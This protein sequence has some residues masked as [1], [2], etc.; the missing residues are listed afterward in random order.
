[1]LEKDIEN[2]I[3]TY[4]DEFFPDE[5]FKLIGQQ[6]VIENKRV[7][8]LFEDKH[9]RQIIVEI[10]RGILTREASGQI[11]EYYGL[12]KTANPNNHYELVLC[13][14]K[15]PAERKSFLEL[16][17][18]DCKEL[19]Y[20]K[21]TEIAKKYDYTFL[22]EKPSYKNQLKRE[23]AVLTEHGHSVS[24]HGDDDKNEASVW[25]FQA[26]ED[27]YD[28]L[29]AL[30]DPKIGNT[31]HWTVSRHKDRIRKGHLGLI[32]ISGSEA[33]IYAVVRVE[34]DPFLG[35]DTAE[36]QRYWIDVDDADDDNLR[37]RLTVIKRLINDPILKE[38]L[39]K[40]PGLQNM[41]VIKSPQGTN[42]RVRDSEWHIIGA[43]I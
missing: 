20:A 3:V 27:I 38:N 14:N 15:I 11:I 9:G 12:L 34:T 41:T 24:F 33:G 40:V 19:G 5:G 4:P 16:T 6:H 18:I 26:K 32:W 21:V 7:D 31:I 2:L 30:N 42:F 17:G 28:I 22:D 35:K 29:N 25:I 10:K 23:E 1:M 37:V 13:A 39:L 36:E 43:M 8:I